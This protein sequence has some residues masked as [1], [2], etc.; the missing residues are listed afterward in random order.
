MA[1]APAILATLGA[2]ALADGSAEWAFVLVALGL[3]V[4]AAVVGHRR[5]GTAWVTAG[6][7][8]GAAGLLVGR[9][10][11]VLGL[12]EVG[13]V[14]AVLGGLVLVGSH[15]ANISRTRACC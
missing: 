13:T 14:I 4:P 12:H 7:A 11:E 9:I 3:A 2:G 1:M 6:F 8:L 15:I 10:G 5:H